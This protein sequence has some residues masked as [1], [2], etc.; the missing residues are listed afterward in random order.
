MSEKILIIKASWLTIYKS[1]S[2][3][4]IV[5][6]FTKH[7]ISCFIKVKTSVALD[8]HTTHPSLVP[9]YFHHPKRTSV[10]TKQSFLILLIS[11]P[12][13]PQIHFLCLWVHMFWSF[14]I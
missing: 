10:P 12:W 5:V 8:T 11:S 3:L 4:K 1:P 14:H 7:K 6:K 9:K 2:S 13:Q